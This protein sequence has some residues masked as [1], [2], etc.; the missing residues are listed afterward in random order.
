MQFVQLSAINREFSDP[1]EQ[2]R[3]EY[4]NESHFHLLNL[5]NFLQAYAPAQ[6]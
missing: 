4:D 6:G 3:H 1:R 2:R 5:G